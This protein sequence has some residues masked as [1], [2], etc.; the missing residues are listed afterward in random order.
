M[1]LDEAGRLGEFAELDE[2]PEQ[3]AAVRR[4]HELG[5]VCRVA[6]QL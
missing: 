4:I 3:A 2:V 5:C 1:R 6:V